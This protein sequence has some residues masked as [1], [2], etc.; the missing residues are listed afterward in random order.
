MER[1]NK[2]ISTAI[3]SSEDTK[4]ILGFIEGAKWADNNQFFIDVMDDLPCNHKEYLDKFEEKTCDCLVAA[5]S[6]YCNLIMYTISYMF[7]INNEWKWPIS[8]YKV[9][10]WKQ[11][12]KI[13]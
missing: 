3:E 4:F 1:I 11:I 6:L 12:P 10:Y 7:K 13:I 5:K 9:I 2:I 8:D